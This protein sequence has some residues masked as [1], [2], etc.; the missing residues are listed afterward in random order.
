MV[1]LH[2]TG[3]VRVND[4]FSKAAEEGG[5]TRF[6]DHY[7]RMALNF[8]TGASKYSWLNQHVFIVEAA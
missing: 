6:E 4:V 7:M 5:V 8:E 1:L 2:Y 3:L